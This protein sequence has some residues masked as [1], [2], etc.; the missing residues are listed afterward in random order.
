MGF[1]LGLG[2]FT[3]AVLTL[4]SAIAVN[5]ADGPVFETSAGPVRAE[6]VASRLENPWSLAFLPDGRLLVTERPGRLRIVDSAGEVGPEVEGVPNVIAA[7]QGGL[8]DVALSP[9]F[10]ETGRVY[11]TYSEPGRDA[12]LDGG[13]GTAL[14]AARLESEG[15][16][17]RL[18]DR[19]VIFRM[20]RY[21]NAGQHFGSRIVVGDD[22]NIWVTL[23]DRG[24]MDR[25]QD[26]F[27]LAGGVAR[28]APDGT[29]PSDN[30]FA[31]GEAANAAFWSIGHRNAQGATLG[32]DG[33]LWTVEHGARGGDEINR[34]EPG[35]NYGWPI[36]TYGVN[37]N[38]R[39]IGIGTEADGFEQPLYYW[40]PSIAPSGLDF[41][42]GDMFPEWEGDLLVGALRSQLMSRLDIEDGAV[43]GEEQ[44]FAGELGRI[45]DVRVGPE[46]AIYLLTDARNGRIIR[47]VPAQ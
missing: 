3:S 38:G 4:G 8:L 21:T 47:I 43:V 26:A 1:K 28:I 13:A 40:D 6:T 15:L 34:P 16:E 9:D 29:I 10:A 36:I 17:G 37:Y 23:G 14:M 44:L 24:D 22:G 39:S 30:P 7:G 46:G 33:A 31:S 11:L 35:L 5:A 18:V 19:S 41:Y 2:F 12:G 32:P 45:R 27:D 20:N 25:A 42:E